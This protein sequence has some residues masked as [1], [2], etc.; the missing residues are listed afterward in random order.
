MKEKQKLSKCWIPDYDYYS[1]CRTSIGTGIF[2]TIKILFTYGTSTWA[3]CSALILSGARNEN[4]V[5]NHLNI[6][7]L[8]VF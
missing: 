2:G 3:F 5:Q 8:N 6:T 7:L 4:I 1:D